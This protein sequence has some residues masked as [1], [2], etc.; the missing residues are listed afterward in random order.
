MFVQLSLDDL[1]FAGR[2]ILSTTLDCLFFNIPLTTLTILIMQYILSIAALAVSF[3]DF[4]RGHACRRS[5]FR[6][7]HKGWH[8]VWDYKR[9]KVSAK[10]KQHE[11]WLTFSVSSSDLVTVKIYSRWTQSFQTARFLSIGRR[12]TT[13]VKSKPEYLLIRPTGR[14]NFATASVRVFLHL[15][16]CRTLTS[17]HPRLPHH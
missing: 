3:I 10:F 8:Y 16:D 14:N 13:R 4:R 17:S 15:Q 7:G 6:Y 1:H 11:L 5:S 12:K 2:R 9:R